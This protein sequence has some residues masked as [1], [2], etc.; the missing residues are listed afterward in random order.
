MFGWIKDEQERLGWLRTTSVIAVGIVFAWSPLDAPADEAAS[1]QAR[2]AAEGSDDWSMLFDQFLQRRAQRTDIER[3]REAAM[4][5]LHQ[6][7]SADRGEF[8]AL[9]QTRRSAADRG[10]W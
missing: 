1:M 2:P 3:P 9:Q 10:S 7:W 4:A 8:V 5:R 6:R